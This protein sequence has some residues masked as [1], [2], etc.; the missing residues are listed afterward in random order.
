MQSMSVDLKH[1]TVPN[2]FV[3]FLYFAG[4]FE[5]SQL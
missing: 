4:H 5:A 1:A 2:I 3:L